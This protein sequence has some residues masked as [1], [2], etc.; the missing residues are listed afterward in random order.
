MQRAAE[1]EL[2]AY[3]RDLQACRARPAPSPLLVQRDATRVALPTAMSSVQSCAAPNELEFELDQPVA[4][5]LLSQAFSQSRNHETLLDWTA[6]YCSAL[7]AQPQTFMRAAPPGGLM[8]LL[9]EPRNYMAEA[10]Y[11][12]ANRYSNAW[13]LYEVVRKGVVEVDLHRRTE[14]ALGRLARGEANSVRV[15]QHVKLVNANGG[16]PANR[17]GRPRELRLRAKI[18]NVATLVVDPAERSAMR[19]VGATVA[20]T[21][22]LGAAERATMMR[23]LSES[24][25]QQQRWGRV[26]ASRGFGYGLAFVNTAYVDAVES[27]LIGADGVRRFN[28]E[29]FVARS[30]GS[31]TGNVVSALAGVGAGAVLVIAA[32][33]VATGAAIAFVGLGVGVLVQAVWSRYGVDRA[34]SNQV[35]RAQG[36]A[37]Q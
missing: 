23:I 1:A 21:G 32:P 8:P 5:L 9:P 36:R 11:G 6:A 31:Q 25:W 30:V 10:A 26:L 15:N 16:Q 4:S 20:R 27:Q 18:S 35:R 28:G 3:L 22:A 33:A 12:E 34:L 14:A 29:E 7:P 24:R 37:A 13:A 19:R 17:A 2:Q